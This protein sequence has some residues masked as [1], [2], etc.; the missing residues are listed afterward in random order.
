[1]SAGSEHRRY[2]R[3]W[4]DYTT[5]AGHRPVREY[6]R[7]LAAEDAAEV[8]AAMDEVVERGLEAAR[9]V[10][11]DLY[12][13]RA[14]G[15]HQTYRILFAPEGR[16]GQVLLAL[17]GFSKKTRKTPPEKIDLALARLRDWRARPGT[18]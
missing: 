17:E 14:W 18:R 13:V 6:I 15:S 9:H 7:S 4:R 10:R 3:Q 12:E 11:E 5:P 16:Y 8:L 2:R 1:M